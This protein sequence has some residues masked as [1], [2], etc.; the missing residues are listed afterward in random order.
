MLVLLRP[1]IDEFLKIVKERAYFKSSQV[2][3]NTPG[4]NSSTRPE[5]GSIILIKSDPLRFTEQVQEW[6]NNHSQRYVGALKLKSLL[7]LSYK[8]QE[9]RTRRTKV[10][11]ELFQLL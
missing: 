2:D 8:S 1:E 10:H 9:S 7:F 3:P 11:D 5:D 4:T 6:G